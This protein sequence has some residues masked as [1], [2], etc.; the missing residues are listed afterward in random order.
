MWFDVGNELRRDDPAYL[1]RECLRDAEIVVGLRNADEVEAARAEGLIDLFI[2]VVRYVPPDP[3][4]TF[5]PELCD[6]ML[7]NTGT[8]DRLH[9][10]LEA[11]ARFAGL[12]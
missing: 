8:L 10:R 3:T 7:P 2:W 12:L 9:E 1:V 4:M 5:G 11:L 6:V